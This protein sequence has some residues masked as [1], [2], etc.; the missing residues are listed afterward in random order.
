[1]GFIIIDSIDPKD[2]FNDGNWL[3]AGTSLAFLALQIL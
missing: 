1:M 3:A 2:C